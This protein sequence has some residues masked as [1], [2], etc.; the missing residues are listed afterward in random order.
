MGT[1]ELGLIPSFPLVDSHCHLVFRQFDDDLVVVASRTIFCGAVL[2]Q[3]AANRAAAAKV[4]RNF[5]YFIIFS[6]PAC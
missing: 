6:Q 1:A 3:P 2:W 5:R 4:S